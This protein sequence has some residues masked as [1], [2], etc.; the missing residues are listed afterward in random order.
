MSSRF[1]MF[2]G[3]QF[4]FGNHVSGRVLASMLQ[5]SS[6]VRCDCAIR[7]HVAFADGSASVVRV[8]LPVVFL[9]ILDGVA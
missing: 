6:R 5:M 7:V 4:G 3:P 9:Q 2:V 8:A 1:F